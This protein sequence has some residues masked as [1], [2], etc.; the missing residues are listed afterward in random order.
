MAVATIHPVA[1]LRRVI[2]ATLRASILS[3]LYSNRRALNR[4]TMA[5]ASE[6]NPTR[7]IHGRLLAVAGSAGGLSAG[8]FGAGALSG[9]GYCG[10][11][12]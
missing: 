2:V 12:F 9:A 6:I 4:D 8:G 11:A 5:A 3:D 10:G 1:M 7:A